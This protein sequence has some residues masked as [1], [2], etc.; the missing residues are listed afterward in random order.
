ML[1]KTTPTFSDPIAR[2]AAIQKA[3]DPALSLWTDWHRARHVSLVLCR[4]QQRL[5]TRMMVNPGIPVLTDGEKKT[6]RTSVA[7]SEEGI[8]GGSR[9]RGVCDD[10]GTPTSGCD[11]QRRGSVS[12][13]YRGK[14][15]NDCW[16]RPGHWRPDGFSMA[17]HRVRSARSEGDCWR[18][19]GL[20]VKPGCYPRGCGAASERSNRG[21][22]G[23]GGARVN[24]SSTY[25]GSVN[26]NTENSDPIV[27]CV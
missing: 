2:A 5:E 9:G 18:S 20:P 4:V 19:A 22:R 17:A 7:A 10:R 15:G 16:R 14:T 27:E 11:S 23:L 13:G 3:N 25:I 12:R 1:P 21:R 26:S 24:G 8:C 6:R